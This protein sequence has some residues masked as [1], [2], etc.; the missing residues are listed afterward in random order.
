VLHK[1]Q[2]DKLYFKINKILTYFLLSSLIALVLAFFYSITSD[3]QLVGYTS[4]DAVYLLLADL[5]S[6]KLSGD[7][8]IYEFIRQK[9]NFPPLYPMILGLLGGNTSNIALAGNITIAFLLISIFLSGIWFWKETNNL[10]FGII[11]TLTMLLLPGTLILS[12]DLWSEFLF[13]VFLYGT[14]LLGRKTT[15]SHPE[16][17]GMSILI[18]L[19]T[20]TRSI[21]IALV[22]AFCF[23]IIFKRVRSGVIYIAIS[24]IPFLY[25]N[26]ARED[27]LDRPNYI[28]TFFSTIT[29]LSTA[30]IMDFLNS[31]IFLIFNSIQWLFTSIETNSLHQFFSLVIVS[32]I[33]ILSF[34]GFATRIKSV[35]LDAI[36]I[37]IYLAIIFV[38]PFD[39][40][41]FI[42][43]FIYPIFPIILFYSFVGTQNILINYRF[44]NSIFIALVTS[45]LIIIFPSTNQYIQRAHANVSSELK[46]YTRQR[47]WLMN[48]SESNAS[49]FAQNSKFILNTLTIISHIVPINDCIYS[50]QAPLV[51]LFS[52]R[53]SGVLPPAYVSD[54]Q[55]SMLTKTCKYFISM[56]L[57]DTEAQYPSYY[58]IERLN[59]SQ[60]KVTA[61]YHDSV[62]ES[63][64]E[65]VL[66][67]RFNDTNRQE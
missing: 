7:N 46:P 10:I 3:D 40:I 37:L 12:Q 8:P 62:G 23:I 55:F 39:S 28:N 31:K 42:S 19:A 22:I 17:L 24:I 35:K 32:L 41:Y 61:Y 49:L 56:P 20:L 54:E 27:S 9:S 21:G 33:L 4:D 64:T 18:A 36:F 1:I 48:T 6:F 16:W 66:L 57:V 5:Y 26:I 58:P 15:L 2:I 14:F 38:W 50:I 59:A 51:M 45:L 13:M 63:G 65:I 52:K 34:F 11:F 25:W 60:Y 67:E 53:I 44:K 30:S 47:E 29:D 43:R